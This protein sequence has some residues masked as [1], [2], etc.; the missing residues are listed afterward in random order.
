MDF[1]QAKEEIR[2]RIDIVDLIGS[3]ITLKRSGSAWKACCPFHNEKTPSFVV[4][5]ER[6]SYH[7]FGCGEHG[8]IFTFLQKQD[9]LSFVDALKQLAEKAGVEID[10]KHDPEASLRKRL[11]TIHAELAEFYRRCL[12][13]TKEAEVA[14][15]YLES[16]KLSPE[17]CERFTIGY[18]PGKTADAIVSWA[19]K[20]NFE[21]SDLVAGGIVLPGRREGDYYDRF[22]GRLMFPIRDAQG[23]VVAFSGRILDPKAHP[24]KYVN[25]PETPIFTKGKILYALEK[26]ARVIVK[27]PH[28]EAIL[29]EGQIDVIRCHACGFENAIASEGTAFTKEQ[30]ALIKRSADNVVLLYDADNAGKKAAIKNGA[31]L[32]AEEI[33]VRVALMPEG[34]DPDS[35][36]RDH[37]P[38]EFRKLL[39]DAISLT[40]FQ[41]ET[42]L[43]KESDPD[44]VGAVTRVGKEVI[45]LIANCPSGIMRAKLL[46]DAAEGLKI[47]LAALEEDLTREIEELKSRS[48]RAEKFKASNRPPAASPAN[49]ADLPQNGR[50]QE[51]ANLAALDAKA[52]NP[53]RQEEEI[54]KDELAA[55]TFL[56]EFENDDEMLRFIAE[57]LPCS[58]FSHRLSRGFAKAVL[59][60][61]ADKESS[62]E[63]YLATLSPEDRSKF[64]KVLIQENKTAFA[65]EFSHAEA[66]QGFIRKL[67]VRE[68]KRNRTAIDGEKEENAQKLFSLSILIKNI[69]NLPWERISPVLKELGSDATSNN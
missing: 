16:R 17:I 48:Q 28:R 55:C 29:C 52:E 63:Q 8:D 32:I 59:G 61:C 44:S 46:A 34:D 35:F 10:E 26:A 54:P 31:A 21:M 6:Q 19:K 22:R 12:L 24:A 51:T 4:N 33:P 69:T 13:R 7:C 37:Q 47:P 25:S 40:S 58:L 5:Q 39:D 15:N 49:D 1:S 43:A 2:A 68:L 60:K 36:L 66:A 67:W 56:L 20:H 45:A 57:H 42:L 23:R 65:K 30:V 41:I 53:E 11:Y 14:R 9:G 18:A 3:R 38:M 50:A 62:I 64:G 27:E